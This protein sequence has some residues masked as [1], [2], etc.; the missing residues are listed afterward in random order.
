VAA[1]ALAHLISPARAPV[2]ST[3][4]VIIATI[5]AIVA[6]VLSIRG[7]RSHFRRRRMVS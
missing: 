7:W 1:Y 3:P 2:I 5:L 6:L 4:V